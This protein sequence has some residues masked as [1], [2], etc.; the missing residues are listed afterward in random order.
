MADWD[1]HF[2]RDF[3][4]SHALFCQQALELGMQVDISPAFG[5]GADGK[6]VHC[7]T[8]KYEPRACGDSCLV[9]STGL[10][11]VEA[12][13]GSAVLSQCLEDWRRVS[14]P[15]CKLILIHA[16]N[17]FGFS[18]FRRVDDANRDLNRNFRDWQRGEA[19]ELVPANEL[20]AKL[21][22]LLNPK[23][24]QRSNRW[25]FW[26]RALMAIR[27]Y[28]FIQVRD[29]VA[30]GQY[31]FPEGLFFGGRGPA[32]QVA[33][34][35]ERFPQWLNGVTR[36]LQLDL[37]TGLGRNGELQL[38]WE[39]KLDATNR[40]RL[41]DCIPPKAKLTELRQD[42]GRQ[43]SDR[44]YAA[45]GSFGSWMVEKRFVPDFHFA[46][47]EFG[48]YA[49]LRVLHALVQE[50]A[51]FDETSLA[52]VGSSKSGQV[53]DNDRKGRRACLPEVTAAKENLL[54]MFSP[55]SQTWRRTVLEESRRIVEGGIRFLR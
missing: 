12:L 51:Y 36:C 48:T 31:D 5:V 52:Q 27:K 11:G 22:P 20:Y 50:N 30:A 13:F 54:E 41:V 2:E 8:A 18:H 19:H 21:N 14:L 43:G 23:K 15:D 28:G 42:A 7:A 17:P 24:G 1:Q 44:V 3:R 55:A 34:L 10:H 49:S 45:N 40:E 35:E 37:H 26:L 39:S 46:V 29:A 47:A 4:V 38:F 6:P 32:P 53:Q 16:L 25:Y 9:I 33:W